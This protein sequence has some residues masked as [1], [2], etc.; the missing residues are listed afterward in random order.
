MVIEQHAAEKQAERERLAAIRSSIPDVAFDTPLDDLGISP[1]VNILLSGEGYPTVGDL[2]YQLKL[3]SDTILALNGIGP[4]AME[5]IEGAIE[6]FLQSVA[7]SDVVAEEDISEEIVQPQEV[8]E[9]G[10]ADEI[11][12]EAGVTLVEESAQEE[13]E[14]LEE[15]AEE[16]PVQEVVDEPLPVAEDQVEELVEEVGETEKMPGEEADEVDSLEDWFKLEDG[17]F[18]FPEVDDYELED[19][20]GL[21]Q[22]GKKK[23]KRKKKYVEMEY[24]PDRDVMLVKRKRK[25]SQDDWMDTWEE[26]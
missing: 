22:K 12:P 6:S 19:E 7:P 17:K 13:M 16:V 18:E 1:R 2:L 9:E 23:K 25:R 14:A 4:K 10:A 20:E 3:D 24:D 11:E 21:P 26:G 8:V 15:S 5:E